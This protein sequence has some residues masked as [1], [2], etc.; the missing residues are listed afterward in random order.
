MELMETCVSAS[1]LSRTIK[2]GIPAHREF[3]WWLFPKEEEEGE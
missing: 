1:R 2:I 3:Y